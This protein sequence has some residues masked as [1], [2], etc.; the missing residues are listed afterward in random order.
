MRAITNFTL[1]PSQEWVRAHRGFIPLLKCK[2]GGLEGPLAGI[3]G[4]GL[5]RVL[6]FLSSF[7][8]FFFF[9]FQR[10]QKK[11]Q[12]KRKKRRIKLVGRKGMERL[13]RGCPFKVGYS[14]RRGPG[15]NYLTFKFT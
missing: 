1:D 11:R 5:G 7:S 14:R 3:R 8:T 2:G 6:V 9:L 4:V 12:G 10:L 15:V 13:S